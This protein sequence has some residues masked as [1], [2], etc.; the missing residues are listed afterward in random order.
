[1]A[2]CSCARPAWTCAGGLVGAS[3]DAL[4]VK[5]RRSVQSHDN[6]ASSSTS[7][8]CNVSS[9]PLSQPAL[10][11]QLAALARRF[12]DHVVGARAL[13]ALGNVRPV[14]DL[15]ERFDVVGLHVHVVQIEGVLPH[16]EL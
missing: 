5:L 14:R 11:V 8:D 13:E 3:L 16:I 7:N 6:S 1:M 15:P 12:R 10:A 9:H 4:N 2:T